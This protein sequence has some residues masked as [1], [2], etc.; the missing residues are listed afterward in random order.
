M[1]ILKPVF[2][3]TVLLLVATTGFSMI[4]AGCAGVS[5]GDAVHIGPDP[6]P[7]QGFRAI[8]HVNGD[9]DFQTYVEMIPT[10]ALVKGHGEALI[11]VRA[12]P[13]PFLVIDGDAN[14]IVEPLP[15]KE[16]EA[17]HAVRVGDILI[18]RNGMAGD[19]NPPGS[20]AGFKAPSPTTV[21]KPTEFPTPAP[22]PGLP[23]APAV[24][25]APAQP[26]PAPAPGKDGPPAGNAP[27]APPLAFGSASADPCPGG[28]CN[29][30][31]PAFPGP[32]R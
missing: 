24:E 25:A 17:M 23:P 29:V 14:V 6:K 20:I 19:L 2:A 10:S 28:R 9:F 13:A 8:A 31:T 12:W 1:K 30:P 5:G 15:G 21:E 4:A 3:F 11:T 7:G 26:N 27:P 32:C 22:T 18:R 16:A